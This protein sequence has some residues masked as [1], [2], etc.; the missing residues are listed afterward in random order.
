MPLVI[1]VLVLL[2]GL[3]IYGVAIVLKARRT[4]FWCVC[5]LA[6]GEPEVGGGYSRAVL[7]VCAA[8]EVRFQSLPWGR[9]VRIPRRAIVDVSPPTDH[10]NVS[11]RDRGRLVIRVRRAAT[12]LD[13][14]PHEWVLA[15]RDP[16]ETAQRIR[17]WL[18]RDRS[19]EG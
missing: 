5:A 9:T 17:D 16:R 8:G 2:A 13:S 11:M 15:C 12:N 10:G 3:A 7:L 6:E 14:T 4:D 18:Q 19:R 1:L